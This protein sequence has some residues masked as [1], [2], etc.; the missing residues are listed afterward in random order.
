MMEKPKITIP[1]LSEKIGIS[2]RSIEKA[3][4]KLKKDGLL[5]RIGSTKSGHWKIIPDSDYKIK[6]W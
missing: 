3:I 2:T 6:A 5:K 1:E 4:S